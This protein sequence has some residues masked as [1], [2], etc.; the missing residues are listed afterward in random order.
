MIV[1]KKYLFT[2]YYF[3]TLLEIYPHVSYCLSVF[4][5]DFIACNISWYNYLNVWLTDNKSITSNNSQNA[6]KHK[7]RNYVK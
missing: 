5:V 1:R 7:I 3:Q 2:I 6:N 4:I